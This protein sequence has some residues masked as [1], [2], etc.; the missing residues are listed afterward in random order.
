VQLAAGLNCALGL[1]D[2]PTGSREPRYR[3]VAHNLPVRRSSH[4]VARD[5]WPAVKLIDI[6]ASL[7]LRWFIH[8]TIMQPSEFRKVVVDNCLLHIRFP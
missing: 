1:E 5:I 7:H 6:G 3:I 4:G 2:N 8:L